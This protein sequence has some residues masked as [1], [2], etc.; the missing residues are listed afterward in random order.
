MAG[1]VDFC[2]DQSQAKEFHNALLE[3]G[4]ESVL[5][6]YPGEGHG[7]RKFPGLVDLN[8]RTVAWF[9]KW[10]PAYT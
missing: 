3:N 1:E 2:V 10:M 9:E 8:V 7:V 6:I 5:V 4:A